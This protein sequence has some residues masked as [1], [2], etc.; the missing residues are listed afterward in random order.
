VPG[1][2]NARNAAIESA[3]GSY[4]V[5]TDDDV[6]VDPDWLGAYDVAF[7]DRPDA[8]IFGGPIVPV[9]EEPAV[10]WF[11]E[12]IRLLDYPLACRDLGNEVIHLSVVK[13]LLPFGANVAVRTEEQRRYRFDPDLGVGPGRQRL[14]EET[15]VIRS[16]LNAGH[17]GYWIPQAKVKHMIGLERQN[18]GYITRY[19]AAAGETAAY[20]EGRR[21]VPVLFG[22]PRWL[23]RR[24]ATRYAF[25]RFKRTILGPKHWLPDLI[26]FAQD[27]AALS[28]WRRLKSDRQRI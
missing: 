19:Y 16:I 13:D 5:W 7:L 21:Q 4:I 22:V 3:R 12:N 23:L 15:L 24:L 28:Y 26:A 20:T 6:V 2:S 18:L 10:H 25:Y 27:K 17:T 9:L 8:A 11:R 14:G 1:L